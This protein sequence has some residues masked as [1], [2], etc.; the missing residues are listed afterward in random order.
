[1]N[2][3]KFKISNLQT[4][5]GSEGGVSVDEVQEMI[6]S[7]ITSLPEGIT[8]AHAQEMI[9]TTV[10]SKPHFTQSQIQ[11]M[12]DTSLVN[13]PTKSEIETLIDAKTAGYDDT[14]V[15]ANYD[16]MITAEPT[17]TEDILYITANDSSQYIWNG[18][19]YELLMDRIADN[20]IESILDGSYEPN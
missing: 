8:E 20:T 3:M 7:A 9:D 19:N 2:I 15:Y 1:M 10:N 16:A 14:K 4:G 12:I 5:G 18:S 11:G 13:H 6:D 17:G